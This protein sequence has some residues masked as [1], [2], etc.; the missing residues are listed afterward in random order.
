MVQFSTYGSE[1]LGNVKVV[2]GKVHDYLAMIMD[3]T[4]EG[5]LKIGMKYYKKYVGQFS[6]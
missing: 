1:D 5:A 4:Q 6:V 2:R 3:Y